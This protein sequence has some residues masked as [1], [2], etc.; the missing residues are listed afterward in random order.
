[1]DL[2]GSGRDADVYA[3][4]GGR[5]LRRYRRGGDVA[6]EADVMRYVAAQNFPAPHVFDAA[7]ADLVMERVEGQLLVESVMA[8]EMEPD[9][10]GETLARLQRL[11]HAVPPRIAANAGDQIIHLDLHPHNVFVTPTGPV[12]IDWTNATEGPPSLDVAVTALILAEAAAGSYVPPESGPVVRRMLT[13]FL[14]ASSS[15]PLDQIA[16]ARE[17]RR[18]DPNLT[19]DEI[20]RLDDAGEL[21]TETWNFVAA[22]TG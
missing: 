2:I 11:L 19:G 17:L 3:L 6:T 21:V 10:A 18:A 22:A 15:E 7:G 12:V 20:D 14:R 9:A 8:G 5:V 13:A 1:M 16:R 4:D